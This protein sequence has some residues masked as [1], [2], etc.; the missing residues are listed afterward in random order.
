MIEFKFAKNFNFDKLLDKTFKLAIY[1]Y[2]YILNEK[3]YIINKMDNDREN[4]YRSDLVRAMKKLRFKYGL[5]FVVLN[6]ESEEDEGNGKGRL[7]I[8][9]EYTKL[10]EYDFNDEFY[11]T[12]ECK[13]FGNTPNYKDYYE[14]GILEFINMKYSPK[15]NYAGMICFVEKIPKNLKNINEIIEKLNNHLKNKNVNTLQQSKHEFKYTYKSKHK[16]TNQKCMILTHLFFDY[17]SI[18]T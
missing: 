2:N 8:K 4:I 12:I 17:T 15:T 7:D 16:R 10:Y 5:N 1:S 6:K 13:R 3:Q 11:H 9:I 18:V 14:N